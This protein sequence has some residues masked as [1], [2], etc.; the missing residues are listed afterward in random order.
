MLDVSFYIFINTSSLYCFCIRLNYF[1]AI[2]V[3]FQNIYSYMNKVTHRK[4]WKNWFLKQSLRIAYLVKK[5]WFLFFYFYFCVSKIQLKNVEIHK[6]HFKG[7]AKRIH[8]AYRQCKYPIVVTN[9]SSDIPHEKLFSS[10]YNL[11][12]LMPYQCYSSK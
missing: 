12:L 3:V 9:N 4:S 6:T 2:T 10:R 7:C 11:G 8:F 1:D 5:S